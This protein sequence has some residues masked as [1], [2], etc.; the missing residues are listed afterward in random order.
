[1]KKIVPIVCCA[2]VSVTLLGPAMDQAQAAE[3]SIVA[4]GWNEFGQTNVPSPNTGFVAVAA[5]YLHSLGLKPDGSIVAWGS[6][7]GD[8]TNIPSPNANFIAIA[9]GSA[10]SLGLKADGSIV[11]WGDATY[12]VPA[13]NSGFVAVAAGSEHSLGLKGDGSIVAWGCDVYWD[14]GQCS[15]P[16]PNT[17]FVAVAAGRYHSLGLKGD[18]SIVA[19]GCGEWMTDGGQCDVPTP[20]SGFVGVAAGAGHSLGLKADGS[21]VA[22]GNNGSG[23][24]NVPAPNADFVAVAGGEYHSLGLKVGNDCQPNGILDDQDIA[25]GTSQD[26][27]RNGVPDECEADCNGNGAADSCDIDL[28]FSRDCNVN[29]VP[30]EC[31]IAAG[32]SQDCNA[33]GIPDDCEWRA[34]LGL[35]SAGSVA[36]GASAEICQFPNQQPH[37]GAFFVP[38]EDTDVTQRAADTFTFLDPTTITSLQWWGLYR[39]VC[40][41]PCQAS[42]D[43]VVSFYVNESGPASTLIRTYALGA[44]VQ[45]FPTGLMI[46]VDAGFEEYQYVAGLN[47]P[48]S[49]DPGKRYWVE[50]RN[51]TPSP[52]VWRWETAPQEPNGNGASLYDTAGDGFGDTD[53]APFDLAFCVFGLPAAQDCNANGIWD[54]EDIAGGTSHDCQPNGIPDEC[55]DDRNYNGIPDACD[56]VSGT[57]KDLNFNGVPDEADCLTTPGDMDG[58][59]DVERDDFA[60]FLGCMG[61]T[62]AELVGGCACADFDLNGTVDFNDYLA[63]SVAAGQPVSGCRVRPANACPDSWTTGGGG[64][65]VAAAFAENESFYDFGQH[66]PIPA[67]FFADGSDAFGGV[68]TFIGTPADPSGVHGDIDTQIEHGPVIFDPNTGTASTSLDIITLNL[69]SRDPITVTYNGGQNA[70]QWIVAVGLSPHYPGPGELTATLDAPGANSGTYDATVYVQPQFL[71]VKRQN[72]IDHVLPECLNYRI[73]DTGEPA[74]QSAAAS[75]SGDRTFDKAGRNTRIPGARRGSRGVSGPGASGTVSAVMPPIT[76]SFIGQPFVR[77]ADSAILEQIHVP[78]CAQGNFVPGVIESG[79][80]GVAAAGQA[81]TCTSH[82]TVGETH[83]FCP[84][85]CQGDDRCRYHVKNGLTM[86]PACKQP[87]FFPSEMLGD[88]CPSGTCGAYFTPPPRNCPGGGVALQTYTSATCDT[89]EST[90][91]GACC[92]D[93]ANCVL[94]SSGLCEGTYM[95]YDS[96]CDS[97]TCPQ[98]GACC[99]ANRTCTSEVRGTCSVTGDIYMGSATKCSA[100]EPSITSP[101]TPSKTEYCVGEDA[102]F[103]IDATSSS[104]N[105]LRYEWKKD[106]TDVGNPLDKTLTLNNIQMTADQAEI[107]CDVSDVCG[108]VASASATLN[109]CRGHLIAGSGCCFDISLTGVGESVQLGNCPIANR[110]DN[111]IRPPTNGCSWSPENPNYTCPVDGSDCHIF[112]HICALPPPFSLPCV[113]WGPSFTPACDNHDNQYSTCYYPGCASPYTD[114]IYGGNLNCLTRADANTKL[115]DDMIAICN[116]FTYT[117]FFWLTADEQLNKCWGHAQWYYGVVDSVSLPFYEVSQAEVCDCCSGLCVK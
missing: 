12:N 106:G 85:E 94:S 116:G 46:P 112:P 22:W 43:F 28:G 16:A 86:T 31:E 87:P 62:R 68:V 109:V 11:T 24:C 92:N 100:Y 36:G 115:R 33:N 6:N 8:L 42:D 114:I 18:G 97:V 14:S 29:G 21:V 52:C 96:R 3:G 27:N 56:I 67:G 19:W 117:Q 26:C 113:Q 60:S 41:E 110:E 47:P 5:G 84:P 15:V 104:G 72:L 90:C 55:E 93:Q 61:R 91:Q 10:H 35:G 78:D 38:V 34:L 107:A 74:A 23:Q 69:I 13:P 50:I 65:G 2:W 95:G 48:L 64:G 71:F 82:I 66:T 89:M 101:P 76:L 58:D 39:D 7:Y 25:H 105:A 77:V 53:L 54:S 59:C 49:L 45:R 57:S 32:T 9:A 75:D 37:N 70:E 108:M 111:G 51:N 20:N 40:G 98:P 30:D 1:M 73:L 63:L 4:W 44:S 103:T 17:G 88:L 81:L 83:Y 102:V 79:G 99:H 80:G